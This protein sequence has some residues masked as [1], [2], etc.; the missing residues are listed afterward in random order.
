MISYAKTVSTEQ[1]SNY[2][3]IVTSGHEDFKKVL[4]YCVDNDIDVRIGL[5]KTDLQTAVDEMQWEESTE[6]DDSEC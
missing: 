4:Q 6:W 1:I 2:A 5:T 3:L